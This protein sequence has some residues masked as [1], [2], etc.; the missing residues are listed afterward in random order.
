M[1][2]SNNTISTLPVIM[3]RMRSLKTLRLDANV[4]QNVHNLQKCKSLLHLDLSRNRL[5]GTCMQ[6]RR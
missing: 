2:L 1:L 3:E 5:R 4:L 6:V